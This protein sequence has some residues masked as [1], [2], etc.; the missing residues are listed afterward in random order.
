VGLTIRARIGSR[1]LVTPAV[2]LL[3]LGAFSPT[4]FAANAKSMQP[5]V[6]TLS[7]TGFAPTVPASISTVVY[8]GTAMVGIAESDVVTGGKTIVMTLFNDTWVP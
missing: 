8:T 7:L 1:G 2:A 4:V 6:N 3:S 5:V